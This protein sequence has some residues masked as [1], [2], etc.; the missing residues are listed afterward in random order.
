MKIEEL[1]GLIFNPLFTAKIIHSFLIGAQSSNK[2]GIKFELINL[3]LPIVFDNKLASESCLLNLNKK[4]Q[5]NKLFLNEHFKIFASN[6]NQRIRDY[7]KITNNALLIL[8]NTNQLNIDNYISVNNSFDYKKET[9]LHVKDIY[10]SAYNLGLILAKKH[11][12]SIFLELK[13]TEL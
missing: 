1:Q 12:N 11:H 9:N 10:K 13:I 7:K 2:K 3:V 8:S 5:I 4:S 6:I